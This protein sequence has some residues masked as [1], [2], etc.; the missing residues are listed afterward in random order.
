[1]YTVTDITELIRD[2]LVRATGSDDADLAQ[3]INNIEK[4][5][6]RPPH[7]YIDW[8]CCDECGSSD[9]REL[10]DPERTGWTADGRFQCPDC[11]PRATSRR[12]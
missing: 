10:I 5:M 7:H 8:I 1:M 3:L 9:C 11:R 4:M 2:N 6:T 12:L